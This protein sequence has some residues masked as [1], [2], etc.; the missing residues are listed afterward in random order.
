[1]LHNLY[2]DSDICCLFVHPTAYWEFV[3]PFKLFEY[4]AYKKPILAVKGTAVGTFV[5]KHQ[6]GW[7]LPYESGAIKDFLLNLEENFKEQKKSSLLANM[8][9]VAKFSTWT[10]RAE[11]VAKSLFSVKTQL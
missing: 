3:V 7:S 1:D 11:F 10:A 9:K 6:I 8:H 2:L 5:E 4:I